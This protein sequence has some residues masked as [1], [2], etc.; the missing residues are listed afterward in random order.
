MTHAY[1]SPGI[2]SAIVLAARGIVRVNQSLSTPW[3]TQH[4][5]EL[6]NS[7]LR[8]GGQI[9]LHSWVICCTSNKWGLW[10]HVLS[11]PRILCSLVASC[12][13]PALWI[14]TANKTVICDD[15]FTAIID[16][17]GVCLSFYKAPQVT[18]FSTFISPTVVFIHLWPC[19]HVSNGLIWTT[20]QLV[21]AV[22]AHVSPL[23]NKQ[24]NRTRREMI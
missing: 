11:D 1:Y 20:G 10:K 6:L 4:H 3:V 8:L 18:N 5:T 2:W 17:F 22:S 21:R 14:S 7:L 9:L 19:K 23:M 15:K 13:F 16:C 12:I 24:E